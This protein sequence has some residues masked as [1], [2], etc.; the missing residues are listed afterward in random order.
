MVVA[1]HRCLVWVKKLPAQRKRGQGIALG[2]RANN[3]NE[4]SQ[5]SRAAILEVRT[6]KR[7]WQ[8]G[9]SWSI[10]EYSYQNRL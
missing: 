1:C 3:G 9:Y 6:R 8:R 10:L 7:I 5:F 4:A 2:N